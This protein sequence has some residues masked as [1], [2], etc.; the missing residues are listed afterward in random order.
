MLFVTTRTLRTISN[1]SDDILSTD[2]P[3]ISNSVSQGSLLFDPVPIQYSN[4][5]HEFDSYFEPIQ[6]MFSAERLTQFYASGD[7]S[8][9][10]SHSRVPY[11][12]T[13]S[14][15]ARDHD[16]GDLYFSDNYS[17]ACDDDYVVVDSPA[18]SNIVSTTSEV[19]ESPVKRVKTTSKRAKD[20]VML[21]KSQ[22]SVAPRELP[23]LHLGESGRMKLKSR[24]SMLIKDDPELRAKVL[25]ISKV[26]LA[27]IGQLLQ[28]A[29][30]CGIWD[31]AVRIGDHFL[32]SS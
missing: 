10:A 22:S 1:A 31:E 24:I 4:T 28:M 12:R 20:E 14:R 27:S 21:I 23:R 29:Y 30:I 15:L 17:T 9:R 5:F 19:S 8:T 26:K 13:A 18:G 32:N 11:K 25:A 2:I 6:S 7:H 3:I 16:T